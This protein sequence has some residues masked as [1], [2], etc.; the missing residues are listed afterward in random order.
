MYVTYTQIKN[1]QKKKEGRINFF[2]FNFAQFIILFDFLLLM[3][4]GIIFSQFLFNI[5][6]FILPPAVIS[7]R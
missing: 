6:F 1:I 3:A 5:F 4:L 2:W 7:L